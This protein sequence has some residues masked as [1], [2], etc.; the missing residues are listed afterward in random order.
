MPSDSLTDGVSI[1]QWTDYSGAENHVFGYESQQPTLRYDPTKLYLGIQFDGDDFLQSEGPTSSFAPSEAT[2]FVVYQGGTYQG[3]LLAIAEQ[4]WNDEFLMFNSSAYHHTS[5]GNW[6]RQGH[7]CIGSI[8][9]NSISV[10]TA[11]FG[12]ET[13]DVQLYIN[14]LASTEMFQIPGVPIDF[15]MAPRLITVGQ[16]AKFVSSEYLEGVLFEVIGFNRKLS[17]AER[18]AVENYLRC[19]FQISSSLCASIL[20]QPCANCRVN[21]DFEITNDTVFIGECIDAK[22]LSTADCPTYDWSIIGSESFSSTDFEPKN[23]CF[24]QSGTPE[25][26]LKVSDYCGTSVERKTITVLDL[27]CNHIVDFSLDNNVLEVGECLQVLNL[28][29]G[30]IHTYKWSLPGSTVETSTESTPPPICYEA[31][32]TYLLSL[33]TESECGKDSVSHEVQVMDPAHGSMPCLYMPNAF[34]PNHDAQNDVYK[35][36]LNSEC[37]ITDFLMSIHDRWGNK[38]FTSNSIEAGWDGNL[39]SKPSSPG[40]Y[41]YLIRAEINGKQYNSSGALHLVK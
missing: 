4:S 6:V 32:G 26:Q 8:H 1:E 11:V 9:Q 34:S 23:I 28:S 18:I 7:Q 24:L 16:R 27:G 3:T 20:D 40:V 12:R 41:V 29:S 31:P 15:K 13:S 33:I 10:A 35:P 30:N 14:G 17:D 25:I 5:S 36:Y 37:I 38:V 2:L 19:K 21:S 22:N 39:A